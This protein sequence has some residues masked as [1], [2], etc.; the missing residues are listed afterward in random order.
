MN[1]S[2][3]GIILAILSLNTFGFLNN[4]IEKIN[5]ITLK[6]L[7][8]SNNRKNNDLK[9]NLKD[10]KKNLKYLKLKVRVKDRGTFQP[11]WFLMNTS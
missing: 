8:P 7:L 3:L 2:D 10:L 4:L 9:K 11:D 1:L 5:N 6:D